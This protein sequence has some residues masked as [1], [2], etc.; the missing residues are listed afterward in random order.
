[1]QWHE[2]LNERAQQAL[3]AVS[4]PVFLIQVTIVALALVAAW[5]A[6]RRV[7]RIERFAALAEQYHWVY[8]LRGAIVRLAP[9]ASALLLIIIGRGVMRSL[10][11]STNLLSIALPLIVAL[12]AVRA[13]V[14]LL[15]LSLGRESQIRGWENTIAIAIWTA[16][17]M[18]LL[19][20]LQ[21]S[22]EAL[23]HPIARFGKFELSIWLVLKML[24]IVGLLIVVARWLGKWIERRVSRAESLNLSMRASI[25]KISH[26]LLIIL[27]VLIGL[28]AAGVDLTALT[29]FAGAVGIGLGFGLQ[30]IASNFIA[31]FVLVMDRSIRPGDVI[32]IGQQSGQS[33]RGTQSF[34][35]VQE[36]R[37]RYLVVR[38]RDGVDTLIP[39]ETLITSEVINWS[40]SD[41]KIRLKLPVTISYADDPEVAL[42]L[43]EHA[44]DSITRVLTDP[45]PAA[46]LIGFGNDGLE[47][48][49]RIWIMDPQAGVVN[50]RSDVNRAIWRLFQEHGITIPFPQRDLRIISTPD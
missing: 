4:S 21:P 22:I 9:P 46:R 34:G 17:A 37:G 10:E 20:W 15:R 30:R 6:G 28:S 44:A 12:I 11:L 5:L 39:N 16:V 2:W 3:E 42:G 31:G 40:Y 23:S 43:L 32:T 19:G 38:D 45:P 29:V 49:L 25:I 35:W 14:F 36:L 7:E 50:V 47:L 8:I 48:E 13:A 18:D 27:S 24:V 26:S 33:G 1:M 41:R